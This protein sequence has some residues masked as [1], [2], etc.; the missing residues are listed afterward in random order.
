ME[1]DHVSVASGMMETIHI[2]SDDGGKQSHPFQ[3]SQSEMSGVRFGYHDQGEHLFQH[4]PDPIRILMKSMNMGILLR[5]VFLPETLGASEG[6]D[7]TFH[8]DAC[9][10][11]GDR[12]FRMKNVLCRSFNQFMVHAFVP[13]ALLGRV[14]GFGGSRILYMTSK[15]IAQRKGRGD[16]SR[17][18]GG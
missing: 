10:G 17:P 11:E 2:L 4:Q 6:R 14:Q 15:M 7:A 13:R 3:F 18:K 16:F 12:F 1:F 5:V 9:S 8:G